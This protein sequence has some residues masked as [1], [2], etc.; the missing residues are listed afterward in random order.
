MNINK[1]DL[2]QAAAR[3]DKAYHQSWP[4]HQEIF[5][6][7]TPDNFSSQ[8]EY[9]KAFSVW[10]EVI[11]I[12]VEGLKLRNRDFVNML[13]SYEIKR[14]RVTNVGSFL[15]ALKKIQV[16]GLENVIVG[17][18]KGGVAKMRAVDIHY[19]VELYSLPA[20][21][22]YE[23][24]WENLNAER[25]KNGLEEIK[26]V[27]TVKNAIREYLPAIVP[28]RYGDSYYRNTINKK[29]KFKRP[30][31]ALERVELDATKLYF[32][33]FD[34]EDKKPRLLFVTIALDVYSNCILAWNFSRSENSTGYINTLRN[35]FSERR[36]LPKLLI[37]DQFPGHNSSEI[38]SMF[39]YMRSL[40]VK[41]HIERSANPRVKGTVESAFNQVCILAKQYPKFGGLNITTNGKDA[42]VSPEEANR[43][44]KQP[45]TKEEVEEIVSLLI[46]DFNMRC[47]KGRS[48]SRKDTF[49]QSER[50]NQINLTEQ[51]RIKLFFESREAKIR[52]G[53]IIFYRN[54]DKIPY[55]LP[56]V[57]YHHKLMDATVRIRY[58]PHEVGD[59]TIHVYDLAT[60]EFMFE[61]NPAK[62]GDAD[63]DK[64]R[65][66]R[67]ELTEYN[68]D[69]KR[70]GIEKLEELK[71]SAFEESQDREILLSPFSNWLSINKDELADQKLYCVVNGSN[72]NTEPFVTS[73]KLQRQRKERELG[74][75]MDRLSDYDEPLPLGYDDDLDATLGCEPVEK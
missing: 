59:D 63:L 27:T 57:D 50:L 52:N 4:K 35:A 25:Q 73:D 23:Q 36:V 10:S 1:S 20:K 60:D 14:P 8:Q 66:Y 70:M 33:Y 21:L 46:Q 51:D 47:K 31:F 67:K 43:L 18:H 58:N 54:Y 40:G 74:P 56:S 12:R 49:L 24:V 3:I 48:I 62:I 15:N 19:C 5:R 37:F 6:K 72:P 53:Q 7:I 71:R 28:K 42:R 61:C 26:T 38:K 45:M 16:E 17:K 9:A 34:S 55:D 13:S 69:L 29:G 64:S 68:K 44:R 11:S 75:K 2:T 32:S 22:T 30:S 39:E 65:D 41:V